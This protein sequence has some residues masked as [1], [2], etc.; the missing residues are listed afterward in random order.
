MFF[1]GYIFSEMASQKWIVLFAFLSL[2]TFMVEVRSSPT[3]LGEV[4]QQLDETFTA[5]E[6]ISY[7]GKSPNWPVK[8]KRRRDEQQRGFFHKVFHRKVLDTLVIH[9]QVDK[10]P[11]RNFYLNFYQGHRT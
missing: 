9:T 7:S 11:C 4:L 8:V 3:C 2:F 6:N 1:F 10:L 5:L